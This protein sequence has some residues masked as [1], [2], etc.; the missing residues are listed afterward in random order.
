MCMMKRRIKKRQEKEDKKEAPQRA[1]EMGFILEG[2]NIFQSL[3]EIKKKK[4]KNVSLF[5]SRSFFPSKAEIRGKINYPLMFN[6]KLVER[7][8]TKQKEIGLVDTPVLFYSFTSPKMVFLIRLTIL[9]SSFCIL[10]NLNL[11]YTPRK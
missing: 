2:T 4:K 7:L 6:L 9:S 3:D 11:L 10:N 1:S 8:K 5:A